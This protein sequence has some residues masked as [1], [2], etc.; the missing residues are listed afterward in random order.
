MLLDRSG[1]IAG[2]YWKLQLP[3]A[4]VS[5]GITPGHSVPVFQTDFGRVAL[6]ICQDAA[7]PEPAREAAIRGAELLL[8][9]IWG[10]KPSL[11]AAR[12]IEQSMWVAASGYDYLSEIVDPLGAVIARVP[13]LNQPDSAVATIDL[14]RRFRE[15]WSGDWRDVSNKQRRSEPYTADEEPWVG[16]PPPPPP[17][18]T[19]PTSAISSP[20]SGATFTAPATIAVSVSAADGDGSVTGVELFANGTLIATDPSA[21]YEF[22]WSNVP[23]GSYALTARA[24][25]NAGAATTSAAVNVTVSTGPPPGSLPAPWQTQ[26]IGAVG[27]AGSA[28]AS[29]GTFTVEGAGA[30]IWGTADA[31][32]YAWQPVNGDVD[33]VAR[34]TSIE[35]VHAWVKAGVMIR[36]SLTPDSRHGLMLVSPGKGL[37]FQRRVAP[38]GLSTHTSGGAGT[39][40]AWVKLERRG[41]VISAYRSDDGV[42][43][44]FVGSDSFAMTADVY[45]GLA[46]SS[47]DNTRVAT[48][49]FDNV[50][51]R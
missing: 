4:E 8:V 34:V 33:V 27:V 42:T 24:T 11:T 25:D 18:N 6:L 36:E 1:A 28:S 39:A 20:T 17:P 12:A 19:P 22:T 14:S 30:D 47:H 38:G 31:F 46:V 15:D 32:R 29:G 48:A 44:T 26:D 23:A 10:G 45:V 37:A 5:G 9:P 49:I 2:K 7:F 40:P 16:D 41:T 3:L 35:Y 43:W 50:T 13:V 21:P 51:V